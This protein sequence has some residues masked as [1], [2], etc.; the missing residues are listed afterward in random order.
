VAVIVRLGVGR[1]LPSPKAR[2]PQGEQAAAAAAAITS[3]PAVMLPNT[4]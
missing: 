3:V 4:A 2:L 1:Q